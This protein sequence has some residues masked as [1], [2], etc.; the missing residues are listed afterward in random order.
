MPEWKQIIRERLQG[1][2]LDGAREAEIV[3]ELAQHLEDRYDAL[4]SAGAS[5]SDARR[6]ALAELNDSGL[7]AEELRKLRH[8]AAPEAI[9]VPAKGAYLSGFGN[10]VKL[11]LRNIGT[12]PA[13]SLMVIG[14]LALGVA[15]NAAIFSIFNGL[16]LRPLP[17]PEAERLIDLDETAPK[18]NLHYTGVSNPDVF[19][20]RE[21]NSTFDGMAFFDNSSLNLSDNGTARRVDGAQ[22]TYD[23]LNVLGLKPALGRTFLAEEDRPK[24][25]HVVMLGY[26]LWQRM[27]RG[28]RDVLGRVLKLD[29]QPYTVIGVLPP[30]AVFPDRAEIWVP[31]AA[32]RDP[33]KSTGWY[34]GGVGRLKRGVSAERAAA[35]LLRVHKA[36]IP[37]GWKDNEITSPILTP[38]RDRYLG[39]F[40]MVSRILLG[41]VAV[42]LLIACVNIAALMLVRGGARAREIAIRTAIGASRGRIV[43]QLLTENLVLAAAG[44]ILGVLLGKLCLEGM[45]S[46]M[47]AD[48]L[49]RWISFAM[50]ARFAVF[51]VAVTGAAALLFG[52]APAVQSSKV[53]ARGALQDSGVRASLSRA[54][55]GTLRAL[56][57]SEI[58]LA[59][60]L[61]VSAGLLVEAFRKVLH[62]DPGF[63][64][65]NVITFGINLPEV[66]YKED[67]QR[68]F[69][70]KLLDRLRAAPGVKSVGGAT[71]TPLGGHWGNFWEAEDNPPLSMN[72]K[73]PVTLQVVATPGYFDAIGM[74]FLA[75]R[76]FRLDEAGP[77]H[78]RTAVVN[79]TFAK[80]Y[81]NGVSPIGKRIRHTGGERKP[82]DWV[83]V[84]GVTRDEKH[85]GLEEEMKP[86]VFLP[87][88]AVPV[89]WMNIVLRG[90]IDPQMLIPPAREILREM[91]ADIPMYDVRTMTERLDRSLWARRAYS[92]LFAAFA[93]IAVLLAAAGIYGV[94]SY[95]V[96]QR[97]QEIGI[98]M[99]LGA[100]PGQVLREVLV[101][102]MVLVCIGLAT[103]LV[104]AFWAVRL[105]QSLLFGVSSRD[106]I[107]Y[108][109]VVLG[110]AAVGL[111]ANFVPARRAASVDPMRA[112]HFE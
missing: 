32:D 35:D 37:A 23:L 44:G 15:G 43:R 112:L 22:V 83:E 77:Q 31:L 88:R 14:M 109:A 18:W 80:H 106:P 75:G 78:V 3:D 71:A 82:T 21:H 42:V 67:A 49:P 11:A 97:T 7:L 61:S 69:F 56:V 8:P 48:N 64:P 24:G 38:L 87:L 92:W 20:W 81:W 101:S 47:P 53:D 104:G 30:E 36:M 28:D 111:A 89:N 39:D 86:G 26:N 76:P 107:I 52:L 102:G 57:V 13:F 17:F 60:V 99:A 34:L 54:R 46:L 91:D 19:V 58:A 94:V 25:P 96:S 105:L 16:F 29:N 98:R 41:G 68:V 73:N 103:G 84:V 51:C 40:R 66:K 110:V 74:T 63:R 108:A 55:R 59:L 45:L 70:E 93:G 100:Q 9:G 6:Q 12:K 90:S 50:D 79:E 5:E 2:K 27:F 1:S 33:A 4:R 62:V 10:D 85:Y 95:A 65:E 72:D